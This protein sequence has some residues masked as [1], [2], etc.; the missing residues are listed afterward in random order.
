MGS[1]YQPVSRKKV[2]L[3]D[4]VLHA[5]EAAACE[6]GAVLSSPILHLIE[7]SPVAL[8]LHVLERDKPK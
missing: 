1:T 4:R 2:E 8:G 3:A 6:D 5:P 7:V